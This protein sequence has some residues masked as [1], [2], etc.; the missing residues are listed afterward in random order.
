MGAARVSGTPGAAS[1]VNDAAAN[2][3]GASQIV[4]TANVADTPGAAPAIKEAAGNA[5]GNNV[6]C[7]SS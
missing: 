3:V 6:D 1:V 2:A 7:R 4:R 5:V